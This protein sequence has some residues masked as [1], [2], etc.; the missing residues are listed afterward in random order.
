[1]HD[2]VKGLWGREAQTFRRE[3]RLDVGK[4]TR[5]GAAR[6][7]ILGFRCPGHPSS[8]TLVASAAQKRNDSPQGLGNLGN[9]G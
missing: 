3:V 9:V 1:M 5:S 7:A 8:S 4:A 2:S 6:Q